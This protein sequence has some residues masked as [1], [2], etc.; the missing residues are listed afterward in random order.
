MFQEQVVMMNKILLPFLII[1]F[2]LF[3]INSIII[4]GLLLFVFMWLRLF[5]IDIDVYVAKIWGK[6]STF[7]YGIK[8]IR[9]GKPTEVG[10]YV[11]P[12]SSFWDIIILGSE[13]SGFFVSK[14][15]VIKWPLIGLAAKTTRTIF[16]NREKGTKAL[17]K[18]LSASEKIFKDNKSIILFP[19]GTRSYDHLKRF[20]KGAFYL[21]FTTGKPIIPVVLNYLPKDN[22]I[23]KKKKDFI[24]ELF[25]QSLTR[26]NSVRIEYL[27][28]IFP[29]N[30]ESIVALKDYTYKIIEE[31]YKQIEAKN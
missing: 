30:F 11:A 4:I 18:M 23:F 29:K 25:L 8:R 3:I 21:S 27:P 13:L 19:E 24:S 26:K 9:I 15:E 20:K 5:N 17:K 6:I 16:I 1:R 10:I 7:I 22:F 14:A 28:P 2:F 31:K 12:H